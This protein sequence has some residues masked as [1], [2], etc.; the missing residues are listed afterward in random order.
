MLVR[1]LL[2][3]HTPSQ[4]RRQGDGGS[5]AAAAAEAAPSSEEEEE[6]EEEEAEKPREEL[7]C[8]LAVIRHGDRTPKQKMKMVV[9]Q[10]RLLALH[11][12]WA[13]S[14]RKQAKLKSADQ[15]QDLLDVTRALLRT[16]DGGEGAPAD[17]EQEEDLEKLRHVKVG[18]G[19]GP[20]FWNVPE[21]ICRRC[22]LWGVFI[23]MRNA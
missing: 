22:S 14:P 10:P 20:F 8:V 18:E 1:N 15:L 2:L 13:G 23:E 19:R 4:R 3:R 17:E 12:K 5:A 16:P 9:R 7:R 11:L 21:E 6:E